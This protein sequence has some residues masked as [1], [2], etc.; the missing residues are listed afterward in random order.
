[1]RVST[2][3]ATLIVLPTYDFRLLTETPHFGWGLYAER[4][5]ELGEKLAILPRSMCLGL[6]AARDGA[7]DG[8]GDGASDGA[9][10][11]EDNSWMGPLEVQALVKKIPRMYPDLR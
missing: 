8:A 1:M 4:D 3:P 11:P 5:I 6:P 2:I 9:S 10:E 7:G